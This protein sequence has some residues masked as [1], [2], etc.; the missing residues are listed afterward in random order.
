MLVAVEVR[1]AMFLS[2]SFST[3]FKIAQIM[4]VPHYTQRVC[5]VKSDNDFGLMGEHN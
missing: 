2:E 3:I 5:L 4:T 1:D